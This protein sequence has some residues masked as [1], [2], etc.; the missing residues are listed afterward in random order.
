MI[1]GP[2]GTMP[3]STP[4]SMSWR[5]GSARSTSTGGLHPTGSFCIAFPFSTQEVLDAATEGCRRLS[6]GERRL[7]I[8][9][10]CGTSA[11]ATTF[12]LS[13]TFLAVLFLGKALS[14]ASVVAAFLL[15]ALMGKPL[16]RWLQKYVTTNP[17]VRTVSIEEVVPAMPPPAMLFGSLALGRAPAMNYLVCTPHAAEPIEV[18][19]RKIGPPGSAV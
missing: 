5:S 18:R 16:G 3:S 15:A 19:I 7:A 10:R 13:A 14:F 17:H 6:G 9:P 2:D 1:A 12:L 11:L 4:P 8:H